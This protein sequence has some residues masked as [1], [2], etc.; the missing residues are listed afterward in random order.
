MVE[1]QE[2]LARESGDYLLRIAEQA[3][4][5]ADSARFLVSSTGPYAQL[6]G[7]IWGGITV[8]GRHGG[9]PAD[10]HLHECDLLLTL[11]AAAEG[12]LARVAGWCDA[13]AFPDDVTAA[14]RRDVGAARQ[15]LAALTDDVRRVRAFFAATPPPSATLEEVER[16]AREADERGAWLPL[17]EAAAQLRQPAKG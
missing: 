15:R 6:L 3:R 5:D 10:R 1:T 13:G 17:S 9:G 14:L 8:R 12:A 4:P 2:Q 7:A 11:A 16:R